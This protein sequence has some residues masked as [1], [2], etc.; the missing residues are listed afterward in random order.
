MIKPIVSSS[1]S[2][3]PEAEQDRW[4]ERVR[5]PHPH[6]RPDRGAEGAGRLREPSRIGADSRPQEAGI[7]G[8]N[9]GGE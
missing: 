4:R 6:R 2:P 1:F 9:K 8:V 3:D 7:S 5:L